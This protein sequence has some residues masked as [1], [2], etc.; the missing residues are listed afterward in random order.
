VGAP[1]GANTRY[2]ETRVEHPSF[3][4]TFLLQI[5]QFSFVQV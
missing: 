4:P 5:W 3:N 2:N 1:D